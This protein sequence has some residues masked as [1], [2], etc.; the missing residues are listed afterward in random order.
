MLARRRST[1]RASGNAFSFLVHSSQCARYAFAYG[2]LASVASA[3]PYLGIRV[4][5]P[6]P[7]TPLEE[8]RP[9]CV[10][11]EIRLPRAAAAGNPAVDHRIERRNEIGE[12]LTFLRLHVFQ[13]HHGQI[14]LRLPKLSSLFAELSGELRQLAGWL[15]GLQC[16]FVRRPCGPVVAGIPLEDQLRHSSSVMLTLSLPAV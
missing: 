3:C 6:V 11:Q 2:L 14:F 15:R 4:Q 10:R 9:S 7:G 1:V 5:A 16:A 8:R 13:P 12:G